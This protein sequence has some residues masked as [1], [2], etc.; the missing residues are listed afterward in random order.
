M[1]SSICLATTVAFLKEDENGV[2]KTDKHGLTPIKLQ[3][4]AGSIPS[5]NVLSG[6]IAERAGFVAGNTYLVSCEETTPDE[7]YGR[8]FIFMPLEKVSGLDIIKL[9]KELGNSIV[10]DVTA[11]EEKTDTNIEAQKKAAEIFGSK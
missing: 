4:L 1:F 10:V 5:N 9:K 7:E 11:S 3:C 6:T 2:L 8:R